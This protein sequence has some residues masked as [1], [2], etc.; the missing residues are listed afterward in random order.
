[1]SLVTTTIAQ[2]LKVDDDYI[3][4]AKY[5]MPVVRVQDSQCELRT[6][7]RRDST[8]ANACNA[9]NS[10]DL[11]AYQSFAYSSTIVIVS[12]DNKELVLP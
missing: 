6:V 4:V 10:I 9:L 12:I 5:R 8:H 7:Q 3:G 1:M 11:V 2:A